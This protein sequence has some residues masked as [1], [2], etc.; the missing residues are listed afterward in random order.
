MIHVRCYIAI[1]LAKGYDKD[2]DTFTV[3]IQDLVDNTLSLLDNES[4]LEP[5]I[6]ND[7]YM[8]RK[9]ELFES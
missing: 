3:Q 7:T 6:T 1:N 2:Y 4:T 9:K 8:K 5:I